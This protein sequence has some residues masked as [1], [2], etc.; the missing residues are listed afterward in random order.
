MTA[1]VFIPTLHFTSLHFAAHPGHR[2][3]TPPKQAHRAVEHTHIQRFIL[4]HQTRHDTLGEGS[5]KARVDTEAGSFGE[6]LRVGSI[7]ISARR[8]AMN[9]C[10]D[11]TAPPCWT[12]CKVSAPG[13]VEACDGLV[14]S[15]E[16]G[17]GSFESTFRHVTSASAL[18]FA[19][20]F[21]LP[22]PRPRPPI[23]LIKACDEITP[24]HTRRGRC[25]PSLLV[26]C[27]LA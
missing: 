8:F 20:T 3:R 6:A 17:S 22:F 11:A 7:I 19:N 21:P 24:G 9:D 13:G 10:G 4:G 15:G 16:F 1:R 27:G 26:H 12:C 5:P 23:T 25:P 2:A 18:P 14:L